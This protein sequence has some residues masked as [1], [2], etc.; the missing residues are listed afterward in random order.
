MASEL[1][2]ED[3]GPNLADGETVGPQP[4]A[5]AGEQAEI[6]LKGKPGYLQ[7]LGEIAI[8]EGEGGPPPREE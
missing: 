3:H 4:A 6:R 2:P 8:W 1:A 7:D 5:A